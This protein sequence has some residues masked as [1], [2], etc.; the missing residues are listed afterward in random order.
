MSNANKNKPEEDKVPVT[1]SAPD[2]VPTPAADP[3]AEAAKII[4]DAEAKAAA[5]VAEA[6]AK[7][8]ADA[9]AKAD[10]EQVTTKADPMEELV[11]YEA[12]LLP[13]VKKRDIL[14]GVN[15]ETIRIQRGVRVQIKRKFYEA[16]QNAAKQEYAAFEAR[17][18]IKKQG[19][20][21]LAAM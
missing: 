4:A 1:G 13:G 14:V 2:P 17:E 20:K 5:I 7:A 11:W 3:N 8:K 18:E 19:E 15:G 16:L 6:E 12:P 21:A 10:E 9:E